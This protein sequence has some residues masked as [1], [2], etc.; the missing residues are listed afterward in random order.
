MATPS[1][2][3]AE[4]LKKTNPEVN[5]KYM[6]MPGIALAFRCD[7]EPFTDIN[8][9]KALQMALNLQEMADTIWGGTAYGGGEPVGNLDPLIQGYALHYEDWPAE[10]Q[11]EYSYNPERARELLADA[12]YPSGFDT[13]I[14]CSASDN[15]DFVQA[16]KSY[17]SDIG[18]ELEINAMDQNQ[19][20][21]I[22]AEGKQ[23]QIC[24]AMG[25]GQF[26]PAGN[27]L[28]FK[29]SNHRWNYTHANDTYFDSVI[30]QFDAATTVE[31]AQAISVEANLYLLEK[32]YEISTFTRS[33]VVMWSPRVKG[34]SGELQTVR[35]VAGWYRARFW[36]DED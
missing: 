13:N 20:M 24:W 28:S 12:G 4:A 6:P 19:Y 36:I 31:E 23:D 25:C 26:M 33:M 27:A 9:R 22:V 5:V 17:W 3:Q 14:V 7:H 21:A 18:V 16:A 10:L 30:A 32:H 2:Q 15:M 8:V 11:A 1:W 34:F 29:K 35:S